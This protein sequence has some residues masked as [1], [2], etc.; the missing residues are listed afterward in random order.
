MLCCNTKHKPSREYRRWW[1]F[2]RVTVL[3]ECQMRCG[4]AAPELS[5]TEGDKNSRVPS[6]AVHDSASS[7]SESSNSG[8]SETSYTEA[9]E[10]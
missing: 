8:M 1:R 3:I 7:T 5:D 2:V 6:G 10:S 9:S 4:S